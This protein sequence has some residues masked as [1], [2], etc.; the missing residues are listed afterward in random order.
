[1][2]RFR[3]QTKLELHLTYTLQLGDRRPSPG[4]S[5]PGVRLHSPTTHLAAPQAGN[6]IFK[7]PCST[8]PERDFSRAQQEDGASNNGAHRREHVAVRC[9]EGDVV[10]ESQIFRQY[11]TLPCHPAW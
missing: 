10:A 4:L 9:V 1:M 2:N 8:P 6:S 3:R 11:V 7:T 5:D